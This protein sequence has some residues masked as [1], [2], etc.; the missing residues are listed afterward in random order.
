M[1]R[2]VASAL[3]A[4]LCASCLPEW[5]PCTPAPGRIC[6]WAGTGASGF[7]GDEGPAAGAELRQPVDLSFGPD[8]R[9]FVVDSGNHLI[10]VVDA[11][12]TIR[13]VAGSGVPGDAVAGPALD[14]R[15]NRPTSVAFDPEGRLVIAGWQNS[16]LFRVTL[17]SHLFEVVAGTGARAYVGDGEPA[18]RAVLDLPVAVA[19][20]P[21]GELHFVDQANQVIR[22]I[23]R[24]G[25]VERFAGTCVIGHCA[26]EEE[27]RACTGNSKTACAPE[28]DADACRKPCAM[29]FAGDGGPALAARLAQPFGQSADPGGRLAF[30]PDG[31]LYFADPGNHRVRRVDPDGRMTTVAGRGTEGHSGDGGHAVD[32]ELNTP[33][34]VEL[35]PD[36]TLFIA[37][38]GNHCVRAIDPA[39]RLRTVAGRCGERGFAGDFGSPREA[40]LDHP[41]GVALDRRGNLYV[42]DTRNDRIRVIGRP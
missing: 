34:D 13:T 22:R 20:S 5:Q 33:T 18:E 16:K 24:S 27:P 21:A 9:A 30:G 15:L 1:R 11:A 12:G 4:A 35:A 8:G 40:L 32:G 38:T 37:D 28:W 26:L 17:E 36:G 19:F 6:T 2:H 29:G 3:A 14:A 10:R 41:F 31:R 42:A 25:Q 23:T 39:G 7:S